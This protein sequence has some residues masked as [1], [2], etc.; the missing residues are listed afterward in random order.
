MKAFI[1]GVVEKLFAHSPVSV[2]SW[3]ASTSLF[4]PCKRRGLEALRMLGDLVER[5]EEEK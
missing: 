4:L 2:S 1:G 5:G 3:F